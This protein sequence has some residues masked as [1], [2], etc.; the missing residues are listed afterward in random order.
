MT[1]TKNEENSDSPQKT[2]KNLNRWMVPSLDGKVRRP[3]S[4][5]SNV[6]VKV[7]GIPAGAALGLCP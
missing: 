3:G 2:P 6:I 4:P 5:Q 7:N 1:K